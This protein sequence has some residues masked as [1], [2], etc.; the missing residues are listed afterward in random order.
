[1]AR[2]RSANRR[3]FV[4][5][6]IVLTSITLI[7]LDSRSGRTG[8]LGAA[9][10][11]AHTVVSPI[12]GAV[13]AVAAPDQRLVERGHRLRPISSARTGRCNAQIA[14]LKG[15]QRD[16]DIVQRRERRAARSCSSLGQGLRY[17]RQARCRARR[18]TAHPG[19]F[20]STITLDRG[21]RGGHRRGH[22]GARARRRGRPRRELVARRLHGSGAHRS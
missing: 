6:L 21:T 1:M 3:R 4:L 2:P 16:A 17:Q 14:E 9:G 19:N 18:S 12:G 22:G 5:A 7:T 13:N 15:Q 11:A 20:E 8:P 10:R